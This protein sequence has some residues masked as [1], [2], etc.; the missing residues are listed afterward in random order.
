MPPV[1]IKTQIRITD[2]I[3]AVAEIKNTIAINFSRKFFFMDFHLLYLIWLHLVISPIN[4]LVTSSK[5]RLSIVF[6]GLFI[7]AIP[8]IAI[9]I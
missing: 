5:D 2:I 6:A 9:A 1:N 4:I 7:T 8:S 3:E